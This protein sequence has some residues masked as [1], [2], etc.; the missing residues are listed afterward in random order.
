MSEGDVRLAIAL[1]VV[2]MLGGLAG[3]FI[4][5]ARFIRRDMNERFARIQRRLEDD[6][7]A[8]VRELVDQ[9]GQR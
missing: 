1:S 5:S 9:R 7:T 6:A 4:A 3:L 8:I 2:L